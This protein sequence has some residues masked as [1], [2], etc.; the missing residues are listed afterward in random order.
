M[1]RREKNERKMGKERE[2]IEKE[3]DRESR[4]PIDS[5]RMSRVLNS[6]AILPLVVYLSNVP[7][8]ARHCDFP[9]YT[10][11]GLQRVDVFR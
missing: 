8:L 7:R 4:Q 11:H 3:R 5:F 10:S 9:I 6:S 2:K 1:R